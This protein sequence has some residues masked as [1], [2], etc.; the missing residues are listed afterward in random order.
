VTG[1]VVLDREHAG[2]LMNHPQR[3]AEVRSSILHELGRAAVP[4]DTTSARRIRL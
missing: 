1:T 3:H 4:D 2:Q